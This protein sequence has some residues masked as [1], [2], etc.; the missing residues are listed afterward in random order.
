MLWNVT[1]FDAGLIMR[2]VLAQTC[3]NTID[4]AVQHSGFAPLSVVLFG[5][6]ITVLPHKTIKLPD[7]GPA[8]TA[9]YIMQLKQTQGVVTV[10]DGK[11]RELIDL[12]LRLH[13]PLYV[14]YVNG[15]EVGIRF[16]WESEDDF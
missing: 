15:Y 5:G 12:A 7:K 3:N 11:D 9:I 2:S 4:A 6:G 8:R 1:A 10:W 14:H 13:L 16:N